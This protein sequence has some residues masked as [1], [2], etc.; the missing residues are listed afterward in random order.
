MLPASKTM[1]NASEPCPSGMVSISTAALEKVSG[2]SM[3]AKPLVPV[4]G[5]TR[6]SA[7]TSR[8]CR[9]KACVVC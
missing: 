8:S 4:L 6:N 9:C 5:T 1:Q 7:A 2:D 3:R